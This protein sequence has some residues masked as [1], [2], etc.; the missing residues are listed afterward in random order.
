MTNGRVLLENHE[1]QYPRSRGVPAH[2]RGGVVVWR[3]AV[4]F[5]RVTGQLGAFDCSPSEHR[6]GTLWRAPRAFICDVA[7]QRRVWPGICRRPTGGRD[8]ALSGPGATSTRAAFGEHQAFI[9]GTGPRP[10]R[11]CRPGGDRRVLDHDGAAAFSIVGTGVTPDPVTGAIL[12]PIYQSTTFVQDSVDQYLSKGY[13]YSRSGNPTVKALELKIAALENG[14]GLH[15]LFDRH[16][17]R[18]GRVPSDAVAPG[19]HAIVS[20]VAYGGTYRL[21]TKIYSRFGVDFSFVD[22][23]NPEAV[24]AAIRPN[25]KLI[26]TETPANPTLK[27]TPIAA[28][29]KIARE[30]GILH[31]VDNTFLTPYYQRPLELG[32]NISVHSTT[33]YF[34]G[35]N[36]TTGG[37]V[38]VDSKELER[39]DALSPERDGR[40]HVAVRR[41]ADAAGH[42]DAVAAHRAPVGERASRS[43]N[44]SRSTRRCSR[45]ATRGSRASRSTRSRRSRRRASARCCGSRS[46]AA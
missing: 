32:A 19:D 16:G 24:R 45:C 20:D 44:S 8:P 31:A 23:A 3:G 34:D 10:R 17:R 6:C 5:R 36:A 18:A 11:T 7:R 42:E 43:P 27:L 12:T 4:E 2:R 35:H 29:S 33:K 37:A 40:D 13:S 14:F 46:R 39:E 26:F 25:T 9:E 28:I 15:V 1:R 21:A 41:V 22:T 38:I 30:R